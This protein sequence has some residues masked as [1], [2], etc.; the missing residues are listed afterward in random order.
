M[1]PIKSP[2]K[3]E[4]VP[5]SGKRSRTPI[6]EVQDVENKLTL[7]LAIEMDVNIPFKPKKKDKKKKDKIE[8]PEKKVKN[9]EVIE[10]KS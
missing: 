5:K 4:K 3:K 1:V 10:M 2:A 7:G 6:V 8:S 9:D